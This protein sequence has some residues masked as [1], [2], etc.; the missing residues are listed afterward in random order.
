MRARVKFRDQTTMRHYRSVHYLRGAAAIMVVVFHIFSNVP[1]M[2]PDLAKTLWLRGGVDIFFVIS[3]FVMVQSTTGRS[4]K[5]LQFLRRRALRIVPM[6]WIATFAVIMQV[7]GDW[8]FK[9]KSLLFIPALNPESKMMQPVLEPGWTLNYEMFFYLVFALTMALKESLR[10]PAV[11]IIFAGFAVAGWATENSALI[12]FYCRPMILEFV[13]GM[14]IARFG[15]RLPAIA[16][17]LGIAAMIIFQSAGADRLITLGIPAT[18]IVAGALSCEDRLPHSKLADFLGSASYS[19]YLFHLL[20]LGFL[21]K[22]WPD[23]ASKELF[24]LG[25]LGLMMLTGCGVY[26]A[27]ERPLITLLTRRKV[28]RAERGLAAA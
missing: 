13:L 2:Q 27:L 17:P 16:V 12:E 9:V 1:F 15:L 18:L 10:L 25:A 21:V 3:G 28:V 24:A 20:A 11:A 7:E 5:A 26:W 22:I 6:Y 4:V 8:L 14:A 19:V 23:G